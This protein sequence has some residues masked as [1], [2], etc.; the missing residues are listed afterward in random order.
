MT[1]CGGRGK[2]QWEQRWRGPRGGGRCGGVRRTSGLG[3]EKQQEGGKEDR[4][5]GDSR[6]C[7]TLHAKAWPL[8]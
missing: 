2:K 5:G 6:R 3:G 1:R 7:W 4:R 8:D